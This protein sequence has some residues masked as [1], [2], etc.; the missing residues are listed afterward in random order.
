MVVIVIQ[1]AI[2]KPPKL[3]MCY[4]IENIDCGLFNFSIFNLWLTI[5]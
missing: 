2:V 1:I 5:I 4:F 3:Q